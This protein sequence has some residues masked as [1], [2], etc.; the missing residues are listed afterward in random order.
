M[1]FTLVITI[2]EIWPCTRWRI[3][4]ADAFRHSRLCEDSKEK[5]ENAKVVHETHLGWVAQAAKDAGAPEEVWNSGDTETITQW[6]K[7][8]P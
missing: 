3:L 7:N 1:A 4:L 8:N 5:A 2:L 6:L